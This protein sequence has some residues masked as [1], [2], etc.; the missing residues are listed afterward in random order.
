[1]TNPHAEML[2]ALPDDTFL[3]TVNALRIVAMDRVS[4][5]LDINSDEQADIVR[6]VAVDPEDPGLFN[7]DCTGVPA[8]EGSA[9]E[10]PAQRRVK[11]VHSGPCPVH[12]DHEYTVTVHGCT[13]AQADQVMAER[14]EHDE[15]YGFP[16]R[17]TWSSVT[18][19]HSA[20]PPSM[21]A[22]RAQDVALSINTVSSAHFTKRH[23]GMSGVVYD[24]STG[25]EYDVR[26]SGDDV[27]YVN[28]D[29]GRTY[30][31]TVLERAILR[32]IEANRGG[33]QT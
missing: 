28:D 16:Y 5:M 19:D 24:T 9:V 15:D 22:Q 2:R 13:Q 7:P 20:L 31:H 8:L 26:L 11:I 17:V 25:I 3:F 27:W 18:D 12:D 21:S 6:A 23:D 29:E 32:A 1:M 14:L 30:E 33:S 4:A 10:D